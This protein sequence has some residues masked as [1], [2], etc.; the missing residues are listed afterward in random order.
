MPV[1]VGFQRLDEAGALLQRAAE[2]KP[3]YGGSLPHHASNSRG[4]ADPERI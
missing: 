3:S 4:I 1:L 2:K